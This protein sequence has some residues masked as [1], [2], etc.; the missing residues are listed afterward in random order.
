ME[1]GYYA[2]DFR[3]AQDL[4]HD[5]YGPQAATIKGSE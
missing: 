1:Q 3:F 4:L 2:S 5:S